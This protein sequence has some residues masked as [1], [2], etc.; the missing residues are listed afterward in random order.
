M[1]LCCTWIAT[2]LYPGTWMCGR[3]H[4]EIDA[5][6]NW[7]AMNLENR[8]N[9]LFIQMPVILLVALSAVSMIVMCESIILKRK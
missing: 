2:L 1:A 9:Y 4:E 7:Y 8:L 3:A 6:S 5:L